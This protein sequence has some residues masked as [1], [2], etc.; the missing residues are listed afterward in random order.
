MTRKDLNVQTWPISGWIATIT[1]RSAPPAAAR[2]VASPKVSMWIRRTS[3]PQTIATSGLCDVAR[4]ALP[5][6]VRCRKRKASA[7]TPAAKANATRR[8]FDRA[9]GPSGM[10]PVRYSTARRSD[11]KASCARFTSPIETPNVSSSEE[12]SGASTTRKTS[13]R[14]STTPTTNSAAIVTGT[15]RYGFSPKAL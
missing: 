9:N 14:W 15:E 1:A 5:S 4:I 13:D 12:S 11:V 10:E 2:A 6:R 3:M 8:V 7:V